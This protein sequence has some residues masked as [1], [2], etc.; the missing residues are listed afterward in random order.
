[1]R[2]RNLVLFLPW[3][4]LAGFLSIAWL[5]FGERLLPS[6]EV[7]VETVVTVRQSTES[8]AP[9]GGD[10]DGLDPWSGSTVFQASGWIEPDPLPTKATALVNGVV[11]SI[12]ILEGQAVAKGQILATLISEDFKLDLASAKSDLA[13]LEAQAVAHESLIEEVEA[14][15]HTLQMQVRAGGMR[16][17]EL[18]DRRDRL[19]RAGGGAVA[20][21]ELES[22]RLMLQTHQSEVDALEAKEGEMK[23]EKKRL[24]A[25][26]GDFESQIDRAETEVARRQLALERTVIRSPIEGVILRLLAVPGQKRMLD[27]DD[28]DSS[29]VAIL[30]EPDSLQ[31]RIDVPLEEASQLTVG[32]AVRLRSSFLPDRDFKGVVTRIVGGADLQRNTLQAKVRVMEPDV[33]LRPDMLCRAEFLRSSLLESGAEKAEGGGGSPRKVER[34]ALFVPEAALIDRNERSARVWAVDSTGERLEERRV[35]LERR[36]KEGYIEVRSGLR[37]G[38]RVVIDPTPKLREGLRVKAQKGGEA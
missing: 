36:S 28:P 27:M 21:A 23:S 8:T 20:E 31:A 25:R 32:Q 16:C 7:A 12:E 30:Y 9:S 26:R 5:L 10:V 2:G 6:Q 33:R 17:L 35:E 15:I 37:P 18:E 3:A 29:T 4:L 34:V 19:E 38:D 11:E 13:A 24:E 1:R 14:R 22:A